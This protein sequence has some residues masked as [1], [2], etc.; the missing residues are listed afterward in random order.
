LGSKLTLVLG[1]TRSGKSAFAEELAKKG[2]VQVTYVA[3]AACLD[4][5]MERRIAKH[6]ETRPLHW[7]TVEATQGIARVIR[8]RASCSQVILV[9]CLTMLVSN[10]LFQR[11]DP[12]LTAEARVLR[13]IRELA[14]AAAESSCRVI[15]VSSE[16]GL[17]LVPENLLGRLYR[18]LLG[19]ANQIVAQKAQDVYLVVAGIPVELKAL[20]QQLKER[21]E[22]EN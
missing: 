5:E 4:Q 15:L 11:E 17:G 7:V 3:T 10:L 8:E 19:E 21:L 16:V 2:G 14:Q 1:G 18:D 22:N 13:E 6:R 20:S 12:S 9:D